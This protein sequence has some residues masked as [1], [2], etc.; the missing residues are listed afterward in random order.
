MC[1]VYCWSRAFD[2]CNVRCEAVPSFAGE[3][4]K[5]LKNTSLKFWVVIKNYNWACFPSAIFEGQFFSA[6][7]L[8]FSRHSI[9][10]KTHKIS[11]LLTSVSWV[12]I[13]SFIIPIFRLNI[14]LTFTQINYSRRLS[15]WKFQFYFLL[16]FEVLKYTKRS[17]SLLS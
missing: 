6:N 11:E 1:W 14:Y 10:S 13:F 8:R 5:S 2:M 9:F 3:K 17:S 7:F 16:F 12:R 15:W 4:Q